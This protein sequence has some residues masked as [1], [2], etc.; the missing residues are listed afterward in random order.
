MRNS[1][2]NLSDLEALML[3][4]I[5]LKVDFWGFKVDDSE[6]ISFLVK[7]ESFCVI[8]KEHPEKDLMWS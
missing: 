6:K 4:D 3:V 8:Q 1:S 5:F 7:F 2:R